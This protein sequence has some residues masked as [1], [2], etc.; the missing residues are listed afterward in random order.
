MAGHVI[1]CLE[2]VDVDI[3]QGERHPLTGVDRFAK[4]F[5][6]GAAI[7]HAGQR[8]VPRRMGEF[9]LAFPLLGH[10]LKCVDRPGDVPGRPRPYRNG[11]VA[12]Q[13]LRSVG[14]GHGQQC[15]R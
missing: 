10:V 5:L 12:H 1:D 9:A 2:I 8:I 13:P 7:E 4:R 11:R 3:E 6:E 15:V 14:S